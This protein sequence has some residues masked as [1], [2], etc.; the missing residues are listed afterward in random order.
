[1]IQLKAHTLQFHFEAGTSRG[2]LTEK[3]SY[4]IQIEKMVKRGSVKRGH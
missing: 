1:M 4:F 2:V 3:T